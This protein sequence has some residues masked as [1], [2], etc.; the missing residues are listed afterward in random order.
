MILTDHQVTLFL[1]ERTS[2]DL[3]SYSWVK[4]RLKK[5]LLLQKKRPK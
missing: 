3:G 4:R 5:H 2:L 1:H